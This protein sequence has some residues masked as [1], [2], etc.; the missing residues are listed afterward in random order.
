MEKTC[1]TCGAPEM[2]ERG[3]AWADDN[4]T[5]GSI[6][7]PHC[8]APVKYI[9]ASAAPPMA[10]APG[11]A[12]APPAAPGA[13]APAPAFDPSQAPAAGMDEAGGDADALDELDED[14][15]LMEKTTDTDGDPSMQR[16]I[17]KTQEV[18][19]ADDDVDPTIDSG[20]PNV[21]SSDAGQPQRPSP[22][23]A[24]MA[25]RKPKVVSM[26]DRKL[27]DLE[28]Q[29]RQLSEKNSETEK[30]LKAFQARERA[31]AAERALAKALRDGKINRRLIGT[32]ET[33]GW[34]RSFA[35][36]D[37]A[38]FTEWLKNAPT[39]VDTTEHGTA[40]A[41]DESVGTMKM[42]EQI[43]KLAKD[44]MKVDGK[45]DYVSATRMAL[46]E[47]PSLATQYDREMSAA[48]GPQVVQAISSHTS[49]K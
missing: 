30:A 49:I 19:A 39:I 10:A 34:A 12:A 8:G 36:R 31:Q 38:G 42:A 37:L 23:A 48:N 45:L 18:S 20:D 43:D 26:S 1:K 16:V 35:L 13:K 21:E 40:R 32:T 17:S 11:G 5:P 25:D 7:C 44:K 47:N 33:P 22:A 3:I 27:K 14:G 9:E 2:N 6:T 4:G 28:D 29:V 41:N 24:S 46:S 15:E